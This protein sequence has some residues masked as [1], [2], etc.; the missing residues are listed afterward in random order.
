MTETFLLAATWLG[1]GCL[2]WLYRSLGCRLARWRD[3]L[4]EHEHDTAWRHDAACN[5]YRDTP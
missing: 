4:I 5:V 3:E 1:V 2:A